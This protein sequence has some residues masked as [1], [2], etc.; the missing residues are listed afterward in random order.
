MAARSSH[1]L[2]RNTSLGTLQRLLDCTALET[3]DF[4]GQEVSGAGQATQSALVVR[5]DNL[6]LRN[7]T[8]R[9]LVTVVSDQQSIISFHSI[10]FFLS[11]SFYSW[12]LC[13][14]FSRRRVLL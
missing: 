8:I 3:I 14:R 13:A 12:C 9:L 2:W 11:F 6:E 1:S 4:M 5:R 7:G 10:S